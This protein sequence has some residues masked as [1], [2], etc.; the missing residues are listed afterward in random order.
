MLFSARPMMSLLST[1]INEVYNGCFFSP[2]NQVNYCT[3]TKMTGTT[4]TGSANG[5]Q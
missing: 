5:A 3:D 4:R 2:Y 1:P